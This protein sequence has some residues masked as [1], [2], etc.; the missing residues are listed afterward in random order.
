M[1][2]IPRLIDANNRRWEAMHFNSSRLGELDIVSKALIAHKAQYQ[3]ISDEIFRQKNVRV[4]WAIISVTDQREHD[5]NL[6][7]CNSYL[8][9]G[10]PLGQVT[11]IVPQGRGPF[12]HHDTDA[13]LRGAF[14][15]GALDALIDVQKVQNWGDWSTGG[16]LTF[17]ETL[18]GLGYADR[19]LASPYIWGATSEQQ[20]GK[21]VADRVFDPAV[22]DSQLGCAA[23]LRYMAGLDSSIPFGPPSAQVSSPLPQPQSKVPPMT[24]VPATT[25]AQVDL[26]ALFMNLLPSLLPA[27]PAV[28]GALFPPAAPFVPIIQAGVNVFVKAQAAGGVSQTPNIQQLV[29]SELY[30]VALALNP[31]LKGT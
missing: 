26:G 16:A 23:M 22:M 27:A 6:G 13:P 30:A 24:T 19:G 21:F 25:T 4:P 2:N 7:L 8:G 11:T 17:L 20:R 1:A 29:A 28:V 3:E 15:R 5:A 12:L 14:F 9:N 31:A 10:Q 18:N